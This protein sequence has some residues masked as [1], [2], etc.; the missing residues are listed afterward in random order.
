M[1]AMCKK[2]TLPIGGSG[3]GSKSYEKGIIFARDLDLGEAIVE[4]DASIVTSAISKPNH[5]PSSI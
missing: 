2:N 5:T 1:G 3:G 4:G